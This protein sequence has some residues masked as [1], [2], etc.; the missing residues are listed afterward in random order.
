MEA[1]GLTLTRRDADGLTTAVSW[2]VPDRDAYDALIRVVTRG[3]GEPASSVM[4]DAGSAAEISR[5]V[6]DNSV[7]F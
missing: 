5:S 1:F 3:F 4:V 2:N 7:E 6:R